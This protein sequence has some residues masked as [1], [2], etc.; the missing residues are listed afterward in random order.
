MAYQTPGVVVNEVSN[1]LLATL[2]SYTLD[3]RIDTINSP[4]ATQDQYNGN[5]FFRYLACFDIIPLGIFTFAISIVLAFVPSVVVMHVA[6][7]KMNGSK[8]LQF[9]SGTHFT[10]YW[11]SNYIFDYT[12]CFL[13]I[14]MII[15]VTCLVNLIRNDQN[16]D[17]YILTSGDNL[18]YFI[19]VVFLSSI[20]WPFY[21]YC[22]A[23]LFSSDVTAFVILFIIL[24]AA[25]FLDVVF[26]F[27]QIFSHIGNDSQDFSSP[28]PVLMYAI[29]IIFCFLF[30][31]VTIKRQLSNLRLRPNNYCIDTLN[32]IVKSN[33][34]LYFTTYYYPRV[35]I[36]VLS[37][38][39]TN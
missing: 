21:S 6:K 1:L 30:P 9:L 25:S 36:F 2:N 28:I 16:T 35:F 32:R 33:L 5:D 15:G 10:S 17:I 4:I 8:S 34:S 29:R 3:K 14:I 37:R 13:N 12:I 38:L 11:L 27:V 18:G 19:L 39:E 20:C 23:Q 24:L 31:N 7:E 22:L 26:A